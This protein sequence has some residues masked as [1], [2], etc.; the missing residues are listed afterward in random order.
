MASVQRRADKFLP[1]DILY[2]KNHLVP[3]IR[4]PKNF[5]YLTDRLPMSNYEDP[6]MFKNKSEAKLK[7]PK[8][9]NS[10]NDYQMPS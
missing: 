1:E 9:T 3:E 5:M 2:D 4:V 8:L 6:Y 10:L 7:L